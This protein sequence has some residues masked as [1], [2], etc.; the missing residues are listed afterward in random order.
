VSAGEEG[1]KLLANLSA[2]GNTP[3]GQKFFE[4]I[5]Q[6]PDPTP[7]E[8]HAAIAALPTP[9]KPPEPNQKGN[10]NG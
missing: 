3:A 8:L 9:G 5:L 10:A 4:L 7:A 1:L 6:N 2:F